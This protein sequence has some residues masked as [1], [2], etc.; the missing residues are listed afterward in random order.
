MSNQLN[1]DDRG[2]ELKSHGAADFPVSAGCL[3]ISQYEDRRFA[4]HWHSEPE[5]TVIVS[6]SMEYQVNDRIFHLS[7]GQGIFVNSNMLHSAWNRKGD[8]EYI[9]VNFEPNFLFGANN[10]RIWKKYLSPV[11][12]SPALSCLVFDE[13]DGEDSCRILSIFREIRELNHNKPPLYEISIVS[14]LYEAMGLMLPA[15][16]KEIAN[17]T[18]SR[19]VKQIMRIKNVIDFVEMHY[20]EPIGLDDLAG[21]CDLSHS[22][23]CR[24]FKS[25][26]KQTPTEY[27]NRVRIR[28][29]LPLLLAGKLTVTEISDRCGFSGSS[30]FAELFRRYMFCTPKQY[31]K[32]ALEQ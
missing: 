7:K 30:Y 13:K 16:E 6:G 11:V 28:K 25:I 22:E 1:I 18:G 23:F 31:V 27:V 32:K 29:S 9:P 3:R 21:V 10:N 14:R 20:A 19:T 5:F 26:M 4:Y 17:V 12:N 24:C 8:C 2:F 15:A